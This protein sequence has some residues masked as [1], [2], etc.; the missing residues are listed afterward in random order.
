ML[1]RSILGGIPQ[2][3]PEHLAANIGRRLSGRGIRRDKTTTL[4]YYWL[5]SWL[6]TPWG[7]GE[8]GFGLAQVSVRDHGGL[9]GGFDATGCTLGGGP[10]FERLALPVG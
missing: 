7:L 6:V 3:K 9:A 2:R 4:G 8:T 5:W 10:G 1:R